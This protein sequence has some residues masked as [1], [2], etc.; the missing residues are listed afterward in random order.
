MRSFLERALPHQPFADAEAVAEFLALPVGVGA[1]Q[2]ERR[3]AVGIVDDV[4][5]ALMRGHHRR[6]FR[7]DQLRHRRQVL[8]PLQHPGELGEVRLEPVLFGVLLRRVLQ[9]ADHL[10]DRVFEGGHLPFGLQGD[11]PGEVALRDGGGDFGDGAHLRRQIGGQLVDV[12][13]EHLPGAGRAGHLRLTAELAFDADFA[14]HRGDLIGER[15]QACRS[16][17]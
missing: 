11:R 2:L 14:R 4:E 10:V 5:D 17:R 6:E 8:L 3:F 13:R 7:E 9:I 15:R 12:L 1:R 16:S